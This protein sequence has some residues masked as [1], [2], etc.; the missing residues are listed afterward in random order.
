MDEFFA[1]GG[2]TSFVD[3]L[4]GVLGIHASTIKVVAVYKGSVIIDFYIMAEEDDENPTATLKKLNKSYASV[5]KS[6]GIDFGAPILSAGADGESFSV[7]FVAR[8][9]RSTGGSGSSG[10]NSRGGSSNR[11]PT[12]ASKRERSP[13]A[14]IAK[15]SD[16]ELWEGDALLEPVIGAKTGDREAETDEAAAVKYPVLIICL[17]VAVLI[18]VVAIILVRVCV[19]KTQNPRLADVKA[20]VDKQCA[21]T[22]SQFHPGQNI[23]N[24]IDI[25]AGNAGKKNMDDFGTTTGAMV[26]QMSA[27]VD[28]KAEMAQKKLKGKKL[29]AR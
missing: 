24:E 10:R 23:D 29:I 19:V 6:G 27:P 17:V 4:A 22:E 28:T 2:T 11:D 18:A 25:F 15:A 20:E 26:P 3:R 7:P 9:D 12:G 14:T 1:D 5:L 21:G 8:T 16:D 13:E